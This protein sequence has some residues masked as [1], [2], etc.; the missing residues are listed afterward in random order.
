MQYEEDQ[1]Y[2][3]SFGVQA[4][5][6]APLYEDPLVE[7]IRVFLEDFLNIGFVTYNGKRISIDGFA[8]ANKPKNIYTIFRDDVKPGADADGNS[9]ESHHLQDRIN[10]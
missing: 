3:W 2:V 8:F 6:D 9:L 4:K 1:D 10:Q 5:D 7:M